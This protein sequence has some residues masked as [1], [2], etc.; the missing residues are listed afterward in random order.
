MADEE[1]Y[2][3]QFEI[4]KASTSHVVDVVEAAT[5]TVYITGE[6]VSTPKGSVRA[7]VD[8]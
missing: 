2:P 4:E 3:S 5:E 7:R 1:F 6:A 8:T